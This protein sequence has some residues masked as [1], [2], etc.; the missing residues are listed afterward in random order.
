VQQRR[1]QGFESPA[2]GSLG[3]KVGDRGHPAHPR[4]LHRQRQPHG[5]L[6]ASLHETRFSWWRVEGVVQ[7]HETKLGSTFTV[8]RTSPRDTKFV[9]RVH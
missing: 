6:K 7:H 4:A 9:C 3:R 1:R 2:P 8:W 5:Q